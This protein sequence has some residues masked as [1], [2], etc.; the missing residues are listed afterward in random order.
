MKTIYYDK[1]KLSLRKNIFNH[2]TE[3]NY[4]YFKQDDITKLW[5]RVSFQ[6]HK[7]KKKLEL[8]DDSLSETQ[9]MYNNGYRKIYD[10]GNYCFRK[11]Y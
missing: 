3:P 4:F 6:K 1:S 5:S 8:F 11:R 2:V 7:L 10:C 9:N